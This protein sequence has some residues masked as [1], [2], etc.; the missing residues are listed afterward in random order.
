MAQTRNES[1]KLLG[2]EYTNV[3][4]PYIPAKELSYL[5]T[6][7]NFSSSDEIKSY[8]FPLTKVYSLIEKPLLKI[9][10]EVHL[11]NNFHECVLS[12]RRSSILFSEDKFALRLKGSGNNFNGFQLGEIL[13]IA[14]NHF[15]IFGCQFKN[16]CI[17]EQYICVN[18]N[19]MLKDYNFICGN[20]PIGYWK[21]DK[22][23]LEKLINEE[24]LNSDILGNF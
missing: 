20:M 9:S 18:I 13:N 12:G 17:R 11:D 24:I 7:S 19:E 3:Y 16:T 10:N 14:E 4:I 23:F 21:Y 8:D 22:S 2:E 6:H 1:I 15:E 5:E